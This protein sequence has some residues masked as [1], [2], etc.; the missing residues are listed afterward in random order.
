MASARGDGQRPSPQDGPSRRGRE[1]A[2]GGNPTVRQREVGIRLRALRVG[3][4]LTVE[5]VGER[6]L[7]SATKIS[8][9]ETGARRISLRDVRD[10]CQIYGVTDQAEVDGLMSLARQAREPG[11]WTQYDDLRLDPYVGLEQDAVAIT[12]FSMYYV[13]SLLQTGDYARAII[14]GI[15][16]R[17]DPRILDQRVE[18]RLRRQQLLEKENPPRY[19][20]LLDE[21]VL[22]RQVGG[23]A[24]MEVQ[25]DKLLKCAEDEVVSIQVIPFDAGAHAAADS[26][27]D[28]LEF[29][30][31]TLQG[32]VVYVEGLLSQIYQ[33][34]PAEIERYR[35][36]IEHLRDSALNARDSMAL[37]AKRRGA[38]S[39]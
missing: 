21:A 35:E 8:R 14:K 24:V 19:R 13:P 23:L 15:A 30:G 34:R 5:D 17:I 6:L 32:P 3:L 36:A 9:L 25:L 1:G 26:N 10:L 22:Y 38:H 27:F 11:W 20:A 28:L 39:A 12:S 16:R 2:Q 7:C 33:E 37:I 29:G 4:G 31:Q 18:A